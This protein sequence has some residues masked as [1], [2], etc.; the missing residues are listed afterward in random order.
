[1]N[2]S[3]LKQTKEQIDLAKSETVQSVYQC[4]VRKN[5][6]YLVSFTQIQFNFARSQTC[7]QISKSLFKMPICVY[8]THV[9]CAVNY[10]EQNQ[11]KCYLKT[12]RAQRTPGPTAST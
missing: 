8:E 7:H 3:S 5:S 12:R 6:C 4:C 10:T 1:M 2:L 9:K 11:I